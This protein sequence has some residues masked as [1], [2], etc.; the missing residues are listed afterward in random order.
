MVGVYDDEAVWKSEWQPGRN[1]L[2]S[3]TCEPRTGRRRRP[4]LNA[5]LLCGNEHLPDFPASLVTRPRL[6][7]LG[8]TAGL[9]GST[10]WRG[11]TNAPPCKCGKWRTPNYRLSFRIT[12]R[13]AGRSAGDAHP[14]EVRPIRKNEKNQNL[15]WRGR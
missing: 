4:R 9:I 1:T 2:T 5:E 15:S 6:F 11:G 3:F 14:D 7:R 12:R 10:R 8:I 13:R